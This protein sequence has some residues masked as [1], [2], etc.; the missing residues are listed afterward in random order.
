[1][2][3][4]EFLISKGITDLG[5]CIPA[6]E[7]EAYLLE[8]MALS[9]TED[10]TEEI[11][12]R[13]HIPICQAVIGVGSFNPALVIP[14]FEESLTRLE[15]QVAYQFLFYINAKGLKFGHNYLQVVH[16]YCIYL[17]TGS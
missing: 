8:F 5:Q 4:I 6:R 15:H 1:M 3:A 14:E 17:K 2:T 12:R 11:L 7:V 13:L 9:K 10:E 16:E